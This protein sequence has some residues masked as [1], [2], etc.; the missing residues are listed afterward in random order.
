MEFCQEYQRS[1]AMFF[2]V[3]PIRRHVFSI[4]LLSGGGNFDHFDSDYKV[5]ILFIY[6]R[7]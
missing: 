4:C 6:T 2:S 3:H 7:D 5:T 1:D